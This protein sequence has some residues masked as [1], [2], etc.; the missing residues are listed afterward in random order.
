MALA[1]NGTSST[2]TRTGG[3]VTGYPFSMF[4][5]VRASKLQVG[6]GVSLAVEPGTYGGYEGHG[7]LGDGTRLRAWST[8]GSS[9]SAYSS[10]AESVG[11]WVPCMVVYPSN[12]LRKVYYGSGLVQSEPTL[13]PQTPSLLNTLSIGKQALRSANFWAGDIACVGI[14]G[15]ELSQ[16][17]YNQLVAGA[18]PS[19]VQTA[20]L[21]DYWSLLTQAASQTGINGRVLTATG[22]AQAASHPIT[23]TTG[24]DSVAPTLTGAITVNNLTSTSYTLSWPVA[25][26]NVAVRAYERSLD[27]GSTWV[28][29]GNVTTLGINGRTPSTTDQVQIRA[30]DAAGNRST[31]ALSASVT[32]PASVDATAPTLTGS[33]TASAITSTSYTLSWPAGSDNTGVTRY[34]CSLDG[35]ST[36]V[37]V[38]NVLTVGISGRSPS[39]TD[40]VRVRAKDAASNVSTPALSTSVTLAA[41]PD[42]T[43]PVFT[44]TI[45]TSNLTG[46]GYT[47]SWPAATDNV[48]VT[49]YERS[50]DGGTTWLNVGNTLTVNISGRSPGTIDQVRVRAKDAIGNTSA[51]LA[52][53]VSL[54][55]SGVGTLTSPPLK[56]NTG[57]VLAA[58]TG[59]TVNVYN[60]SSGVLIVQKRGLASDAA[61]V[62]VISDSAIVTGTVCAYEVVTPA[63][64]RRL[65]T[66][67]AA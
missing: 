35:G 50:L 53:A 46:A 19:S 10:R 36:W 25:T 21:V 24:T 47:L 28:D 40:A 32:L 4:A 49:S 8:I 51:P 17:D 12:K 63:S 62:V 38:G 15:V 31:P 61:G 39:S 9:V 42:V 13:V 60:A 34:E 16:T 11:D 29:V 23:E 7:M 6:F 55:A 20:S 18:V 67:T 5:W 43:A 58:L 33:L 14:W 44:G 52:T 2:L 57:T 3:I 56:N 41:G 54:P 30:L 37:D 1:F 27:S 26:D 48:A 45:T 66:A 65:P 59:L 22:T 64:G